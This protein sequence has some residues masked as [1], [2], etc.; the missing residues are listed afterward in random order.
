MPVGTG[1]A[2]ARC[3]RRSTAFFHTTWL[4]PSRRRFHSF[5]LSAGCTYMNTRRE[6]V[7]VCGEITN[8]TALA[9][10]MSR[11]LTEKKMRRKTSPVKMRAGSRHGRWRWPLD[12]IPVCTT[13]SHFLDS[14]PP[15]LQPHKCEDEE[16]KEKKVKEKKRNKPCR[17]LSKGFLLFLLFLSHFRGDGTTASLLKIKTEKKQTNF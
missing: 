1:C 15:P 10:Q 7:C 16:K 9:W 5:L 17:S 6:C 3:Q 8:E 14:H 4:S 11:A 13:V 12:D 2:G